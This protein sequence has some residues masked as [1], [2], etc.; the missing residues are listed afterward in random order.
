MAIDHGSDALS[1]WASGPIATL[2]ARVAGVITVTLTGGNGGWWWPSWLIDEALDQFEPG[3]VPILDGHNDTNRPAPIVG[4]VRALARCVEGLRFAGEVTDL[5]MI[6]RLRY[7]G[8]A[9]SPEER[10]PFP[11]AH[12]PRSI[13][14]YPRDDA[15]PGP[16]LAVAVLTPWQRPARP[17]SCLWLTGGVE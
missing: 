9:V 6:D 3:T 12:N 13:I 14:V 15:A 16:L 17:G 4:Q 8:A 7:R 1:S 10:E 5:R 11:S 2:A